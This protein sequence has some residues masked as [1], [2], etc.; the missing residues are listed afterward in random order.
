MK[1]QVVREHEE[2][3]VIRR[4]VLQ[5]EPSQREVKYWLMAAAFALSL[6]IVAEVAGLRSDVAQ[7]ATPVDTVAVTTARA[8]M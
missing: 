2:D 6:G 3:A 4:D 8:A 7:K 5:P 1:Q